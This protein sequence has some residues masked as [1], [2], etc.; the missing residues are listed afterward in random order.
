MQLVIKFNVLLIEDNEGD[1]LLV[2]DYL[3]E[4]FNSVEI[5]HCCLLQEA[6]VSLRKNEYDVILKDLSLPDSNGMIS[7]LE[8]LSLAKAA[9]VIVLTGRDDKQLAIETLKLGVEDYLVKD[10][11]SAT[12]LQKS[13]SYGIERNK[14]RLIISNSEKRFRSIIAN[15]TDGFALIGA[16]GNIQDISSFGKEIIGFNWAENGGFF[17]VEFLHPDHR[18]AVINTFLEVVKK[19]GEIKLLEFKYKIPNAGYRW[20]EST[21]YNLLEDSAVRAVVLN[22]RDITKRKTEEEERN[23]LIEEL[24]QTNA[25]LKQFGF[26]TSHNL[27]A[28]VTN[29]LS[30]VD[31]LEPEKITDNKTQALVSAFKTASFQLNDTL[32]DLINILV[33]REKKYLALHQISFQE[34]VEK[35]I[36]NLRELLNTESISISTDFS[37]AP[38]IVFDPSY[39]ESILINLFTNSIKFASPDRKLQISIRS[40]KLN[41]EIVLDFTDNGI[42]MNMK[43]IK[44]RIFGLYQRFHDKPDSKGIGLYLI[45][46]Q[47]TALGGKITVDS[48]VDKG[49]TF[50]IAFKNQQI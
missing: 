4:I 6:L 29:L 46:S 30:I 28:P 21:F 23:I 19:P 50:S 12:I 18:T 11:V 48:E 34:T 38:S 20:L 45:K 42:G 27:R 13:I 10:E 41:E 22:Y 2:K 44:D 7:I 47:V 1:F 32:N 3:T 35:N 9:P 26:I 36:H 31:L 40:H 33:I 5:T 15:S 17:R 25:D 16:N 8:I 24:L 37:A 49:T 39:L 43:Y 14:S